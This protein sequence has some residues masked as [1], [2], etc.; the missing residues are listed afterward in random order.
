M[1]TIS[2]IVTVYNQQQYI[3]KCLETICGQSYQ[4]L[5]ILLVDDGSVDG[6]GDICD[7]YAQRDGRI[8]VI[9]QENRGVSAARNAGLQAAS[10]K[11]VAFVDGDDYLHPDIYRSLHQLSVQEEADIA[12]CPFYF[13]YRTGVKR[14]T[15][16]EKAGVYGADAYLS[17]IAKDSFA[18]Y[19]SVVWNKLIRAK[20]LRE[21]S[22][23][24]DEGLRIMEDMKFTFSLLEKIGRIAVADEPMYYYRKDNAAAVTTGPI[25]FADSYR[26][27]ML[28]YE[29][30]ER[31]YRSH[32]LYEVYRRT[33]AD[34]LLRYQAS[35]LFKALQAPERKEALSEH[36]SIVR[37]KEFRDRVEQVSRGYRFSRLLLWDIRNFRDMLVDRARRLKRRIMEKS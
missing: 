16:R 35:Q 31:L 20:I 37:Q 29:I 21:N 17:H 19:Y 32:G 22:L 6:S 14:D 2:V 8:H 36:G 5:E 18:F 7:R 26:N 11:Y 4:E 23:W 15:A 1:D 3:E 12:V 9:H 28:G 13:I 34:Y 30:M 25:A 33:M 10:G 27:R 24:F